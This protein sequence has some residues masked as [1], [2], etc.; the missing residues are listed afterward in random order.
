MKNKRIVKVA[1]IGSGFAA[2][3]HAEAYEKVV[4]ID[5]QI[6][7]VAVAPKDKEMAEKFCKKYNFDAKIY[8]DADEMIKET[9][10]DVIDLVV[11]TFLH[12]PFA[13]KAA[14]AGKNV[15]CEKPLTGYFG[16][17]KIPISER[18][19]VGLTDKKIMLQECLKDCQR[20][21]EAFNKSGT[22]FCYAE[23][24]CYA[25]PVSKAKELLK[26]SKGKILEIRCGESHS[27]SHSPFAAEWKYT[28]GGALIRM[29]AHPYGVA[30]HLKLWEG[31]VRN[32]KPILPK[33]V[34]A[35]T[36]KCRDMLKKIPK[37]QDR[38]VSRPIDVED[39]STGIIT[40]ED[41]TNAT[42]IASDV[43]L[44]GI[45]N[46]INIYASNCRIEGKISNNDT[47]M[48]YAPTETEFKEAYTIEKTETKV[49]WTNAQPD[50]DWMTGY[51]FEIQDFMESIL[52]KKQPVSNLNLAIWCT[53]TM[54]AA[55]LSAEIGKRIEIPKNFDF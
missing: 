47:L 14:K 31:M 44:G 21:N 5:V 18:K 27:G 33:S 29:G 49:G 1:M 25:P 50:E 46:W 36:T 40:F 11:P 7:A 52:E 34:I 54:Y 39:W 43:T 37:E 15:I 13:I 30:V 28:G 17:L 22:I 9:D 38:I 42:V 4:G 53:K 35:T 3:K 23:N 45:E 26:S 6:V 16:D 19:D 51:P 48:A 24:W 20:I 10:A 8:T 55:Y 12:V 32:G 2:N 41:G